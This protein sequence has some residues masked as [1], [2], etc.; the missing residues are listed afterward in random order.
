MNSPLAI[1]SARHLAH[2][3]A[4]AALRSKEERVA[5]IDTAILARPPVA[6]EMQ[7][8]LDDV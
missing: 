7:I 5:A 3:D 4:F 8:C 2:T 6:Q 1:E